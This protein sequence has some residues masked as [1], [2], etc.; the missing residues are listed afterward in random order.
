M[1]AASSALIPA[2]VSKSI[3]SSAISASSN[4]CD[5]AS[6]KDAVGTE[7]LVKCQTKRCWSSL[8]PNSEEH[9]IRDLF[10]LNRQ[11]HPVTKSDTTGQV[12]FEHRMIPTPLD[13]S[14]HM[15]PSSSQPSSHSLSNAT[16]LLDTSIRHD[17]DTSDRG[18]L[19]ID[20]R[21]KFD[22]P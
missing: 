8:I 12:F 11:L 13:Q 4:V 6:A 19:F 7:H 15:H 22:H 2:S 20:L 14:D 18:G 21:A 5:K 9:A 17:C 1:E 10:F 16:R 3:Q